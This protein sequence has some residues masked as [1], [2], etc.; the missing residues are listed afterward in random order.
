[1]KSD[2]DDDFG[3]FDSDD[4]NDQPA[5]VSSSED[6]NVFFVPPVPIPDTQ[7]DALTTVSDVEPEQGTVKTDDD[8]SN[9]IKK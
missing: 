3:D 2:K 9:E 5:N 7:S 4:F 8:L 1:M 6:K